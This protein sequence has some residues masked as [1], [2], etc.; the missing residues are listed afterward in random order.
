MLKKGSGRV[1]ENLLLGGICCLVVD[2]VKCFLPFKLY[3]PQIDSWR[4]QG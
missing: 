2:Y 4:C 1:E 3:V